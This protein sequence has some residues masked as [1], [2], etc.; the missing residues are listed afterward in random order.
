MGAPNI[1]N[2]LPGKKSIINTADFSG[3]R[4]LAEYI[5]HLN[6]NDEEYEEYFDWKKQ[7]LSENFKD[8]YSVSKKQ[9]EFS[10]RV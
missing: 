1:D 4:E 2:W 10:R 6:E 8:K 9:E 5:N 7:G 3:A